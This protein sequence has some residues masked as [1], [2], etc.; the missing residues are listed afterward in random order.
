LITSDVAA[1]GLTAC[2]AFWRWLKRPT[3]IST[4]VSGVVLGVAELAKTTLVVFYPLWPLMW[5]IYRWPVWRAPLTP[6]P[7][8]ARG[9]G[10]TELKVSSA[11]RGEGRVTVGNSRSE[12]STLADGTRSMPA[13]TELAMLVARMVVALYVVN[14]GYGFE[15]SGKRLVLC[16]TSNF[17]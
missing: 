14:L 6:G 9:E 5:V 17:G 12:F 4:I 2:Y 1:L 15:G 13:A 8:P 11:A 3:W 7:S 10:G 16:Q